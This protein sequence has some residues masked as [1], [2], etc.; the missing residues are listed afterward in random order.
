M[1][2]PIIFGL[3]AESLGLGG[4]CLLATLRWLVAGD[5]APL[6]ALPSSA[7]STLVGNAYRP[8]VLHW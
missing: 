5:H 4:D 3:D 2:Y 1:I 8:I 6:Q 7:R